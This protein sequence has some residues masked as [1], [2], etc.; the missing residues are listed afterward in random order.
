MQAI[1][2]AERLAVR[3]T[4]PVWLQP[5]V[6]G[7][8]VGVLA[9]WFPQ[10]LGVGY[11]T[12]DAALRAEFGLALLVALAVAKIVA[13]ACCLGFGMGGGIVSPSL[14]LGALVGGAFGVIAGDVFP[15]LFSGVSAYALIGTGA[16]AGAVLGAPLAAIF[17]IFELTG[18]SS[19]MIAVMIAAGI[20]SLATSQ[21]YARS[22]FSRQLRGRGV[23]LSGGHEQALLRSIRVADVMKRQ[24]GTID[25]GAGVSEMNA[26]LSATPYGELYVTD[27]DRRVQAILGYAELGRAVLDADDPATLAAGAVA[28]P[29]GPVLTIADDLE[30][31]MVL[32]NREGEHV[33][34]VVTDK[35]SMRLCGLIRELDVSQAYNRA[36][37]RARDEE[38][39]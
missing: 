22:Y 12:M 19:M 33:V 25:A 35:D 9:I 3:S 1:F 4:L 38:H 20:A 26:A 6:G 10:V 13:T 14:Y 8:V 5:A 15:A 36:L 28:R 2:A 27:P 23:V 39:A 34:P 24:Y 18:S 30:R 37:L 31:A 11:L 16:V 17:I 7:L 32:I 21:F 29:I